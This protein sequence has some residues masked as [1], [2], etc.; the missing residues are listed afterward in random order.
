[1]ECEEVWFYWPLTALGWDREEHLHRTR[2]TNSSC[3]G[4]NMGYLPAIPPRAERRNAKGPVPRS[5]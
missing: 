4:L 1:M 3:L 2:L 5:R